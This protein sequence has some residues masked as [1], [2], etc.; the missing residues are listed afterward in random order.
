[1]CICLGSCLGC[2]CCLCMNKKKILEQ[3]K[4]IEQKIKE[5]E[6]LESTIRRLEK[7]EKITKINKD[8]YSDI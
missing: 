1:M 3:E 5:L 6:I 4:L 7:L 8:I 2:K